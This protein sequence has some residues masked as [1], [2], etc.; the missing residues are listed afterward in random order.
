M[1]LPIAPIF[2]A[3]TMRKARITTKMISLCVPMDSTRGP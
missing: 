3:M 1:A 2:V